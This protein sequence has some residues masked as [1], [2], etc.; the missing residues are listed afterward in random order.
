[1][2]KLFMKD[3]FRQRKRFFLTSLAI[4]WGTISMVLFLAFGEGMKHSFRVGS[5]GLGESI[6]IM[7]GSSTQKAYKGLG[8]GRRIRL[9]SADQNFIQ[10]Q[11][12]EIESIAAELK[13]SG[14]VIEHGD[15]LATERVIGTYPAF[16]DLRTHYAVAGGRFINEMDVKNQRRVIFLGNEIEAELFGGMERS[17]SFF[18]QKEVAAEDRPSVQETIGK[19]VLV[20]GV[21]F[22]VIGV[23]TKKNQTS[24]YGG[25]DSRHVVIPGSTFQ[26][27]YGIRTLDRMIIK[28]A[29]VSQSEYVE[30]RVRQVLS[31]KY[32]FDP[33]DERAVY[34]WDVIEQEQIMGNVMLG[35]QLFLGL[36]GAMTLCI[37]GGGVANIMY[38]IIR[39]RT[40]EIGL[41]MAI[42]AKRR[43]VLSTILIEALVVTLIGGLVGLPASWGIIE[44]YNAMPIDNMALEFLGKPIMSM[45]V[46][47]GTIVFLGFVGLVAGFFPARK[48]ANLN[49][50]EALR[51]E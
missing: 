4:A 8:T 17:Q 47:L 40:R 20:G 41:K 15:E 48:A 46:A 14:V 33:T 10:Q 43:N 36:V 23:M 1:M 26:T 3:L 49:P 11:I 9:E 51:Y 21:P 5:A 18:N 7:G 44:G 24:M 31:G 45:E 27:L 39:K 50:V 19:T 37:A 12:P 13:K 42:G 22:T 16:E 29:K 30:T 32:Q 25:P 34:C 2:F 35:I 28:P 6:L 38:V